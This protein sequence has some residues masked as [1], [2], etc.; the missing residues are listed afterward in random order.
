MLVALG[1]QVDAWLDGALGE[2]GLSLRLFG[3]LGHL[4]RGSGLSYT[5]LARRARV[6]PQSMHATVARLIELGAV[7]PAGPGRGKRALLDVTPGG[8]DLLA[9]GQAVLASV[10]A[11][12]RDVGG[13]PGDPDLFRMVGEVSGRSRGPAGVGDP[14]R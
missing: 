10:D 6:T 2:V 5:E 9:A 11:E 12:L 1:R 13:L 14:P 3:A 4:A 7:A 8:R